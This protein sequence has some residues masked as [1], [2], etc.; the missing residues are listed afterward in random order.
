MGRWADTF[1]SLVKHFTGCSE[2]ISYYIYIKTALIAG[3]NYK[4]YKYSIKKK[5]SNLF[6]TFQNK[7]LWKFIFSSSNNNSHLILTEISIS[8]E[9]LSMSSLNAQTKIWYIKRFVFG[10]KQ[11]YNSKVFKK[12]SHNIIINGLI[13]HRA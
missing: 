5:I 3:T 10:Y 2:K 13:V 8:N 11:N 6:K 12:I 4:Q 1:C 9:R 7:T